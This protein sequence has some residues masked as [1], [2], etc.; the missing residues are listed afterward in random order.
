MDREIRDWSTKVHFPRQ[1]TL[2]EQLS[3]LTPKVRSLD[4]GVQK[5]QTEN[6]CVQESL[7]DVVEALFW[8]QQ[9]VGMRP[10]HY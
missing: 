5:L 3:M 9:V 4:V 7:K 8:L 10:M 2:E 6:H 1:D